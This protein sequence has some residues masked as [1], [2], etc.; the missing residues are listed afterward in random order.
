MFPSKSDDS[1]LNSGTPPINKL[2]LVNMGEH[3]QDQAKQKQFT[4]KSPWS[5][6]GRQSICQQLAQGFL[7]SPSRSGKIGYPKNMRRPAPTDS[8]CTLTCPRSDRAPFGTAF[9]GARARPKGFQKKQ[10][11]H[12]DNSR[13][14]QRPVG[15]RKHRKQISSPPEP[16]P[17]PDWH[18]P[19]V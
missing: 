12:L 3:Y 11:L 10:A 7:G 18:S 6:D 2:A 19:A 8:G 4:G 15:H 9:F 13:L 16:P 1:P 17:A 14:L 5:Q